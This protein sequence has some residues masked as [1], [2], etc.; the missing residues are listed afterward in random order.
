MSGGGGFVNQPAQWGR[1]AQPQTGACF[2]QHENF[3][4]QYFCTNSGASAAEVPLVTKDP[5]DSISSVRVFG[6]AEVTVFRATNFG[7][8]SFSFDADIPNL[9]QAGWNDL[10]ASLRVGAPTF[11]RGNRGFGGARGGGRFGRGNDTGL[12]VFSD[13]DFGGQSAM[14]TTTT[15]NL[16]ASGMA[17]TISSLRVAPGQSWQ[18]CTEPN[19][20]GRCQVVTGEMTD[21]RPGQWSDVIQSVR[22]L[23]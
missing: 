20:Q 9:E 5:N 23:K 18:V 16:G 1:G 10:V 19:Y 21:L 13:V 4:G 14:F 17:R 7:G 22:R 12:E 3:C 8:Q 15:P 6:G 2:Y 11:G